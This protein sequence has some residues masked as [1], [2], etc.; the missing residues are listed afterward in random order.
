L[1]STAVG[2]GEKEEEKKRNVSD[3]PGATISNTDLLFYEVYGD[4]VHQNSGQH[5]DG[6]IADDELWQNY[7][8]RIIVYPS[9]TYAALSGAVG[10]RFVD[11]LAVILEGIKS[12]K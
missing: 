4:Y 9:L 5:L 2:E 12:R 6:G 3:L 7:W 1:R 10:R 11:M 8:R